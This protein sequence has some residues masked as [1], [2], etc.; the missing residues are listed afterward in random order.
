[1]NNR[2]S[3][4][5]SLDGLFRQ[6]IVLMSGLVTAPIIVAATTFERALVLTLSFFLISYSSIIIC[7]FI[8]REIV[9]TVRIICYVGVASVMYIPTAL[10]MNALFPETASAVSI[11]I[12]ILV[13]NSLILAKTESRFYL[14]PLREMAVDA[15]MYILGYAAAGFSEVILANTRYP[16][17]NP[18][19]YSN[20]LRQLNISDDSARLDALWNVITACQKAAG[21]TRVTVEMNDS[22][23]FADSTALTTA[24][25][26]GDRTKLKT[27]ALLVDYSPED[28]TGYAETRAFI[29]RVSAMFSGQEWAVRIKTSGFSATA[30]EQVRKAFAD[31]GVTVYSE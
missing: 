16:L 28:K 3:G 21:E 22:D 7:R 4:K 29:G 26:S 23:L 31:S 24:E 9:Y 15:L 17:F 10:L 6:N 18:Q 19:D 30:L 14:M 8:P 25:L 1:M 12:E 5:F 11:Y 20:F 27:A 13:V 2:P